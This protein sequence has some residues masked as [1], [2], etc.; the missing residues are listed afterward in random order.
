VRFEIDIGDQTD[1]LGNDLFSG[2]HKIFL[3]QTNKIA[4]LISSCSQHF[5]DVRDSGTSNSVRGRTSNIA[6]S[7]TGAVS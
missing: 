6:N 4:K 2:S 1:G 7:V 5:S 3:N